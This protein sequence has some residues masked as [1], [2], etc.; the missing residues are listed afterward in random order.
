MNTL[1]QVRARA[2]AVWE[3]AGLMDQS[4][5]VTAAPLTVEEAIGK[6][7]IKRM[8]PMQAGD[9]HATWADSEPLHT[10]T[11]LRPATPLKQGVA[12]FVRWYIDY[13]R[14]AP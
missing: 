8:L 4:V 14:P 5:C 11:G 12:E 7:A 6:P 2:I 9:M 13:Y 10:L 1:E 3:E